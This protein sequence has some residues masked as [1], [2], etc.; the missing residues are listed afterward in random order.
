MRLAAIFLFLVGLLCL[1]QAQVPLTHA[2]KGAPGGAGCSKAT[3]A[4]AAYDGG[5]NTAAVTTLLCGLVTDGVPLDALWLLTINSVGNAEINSWNP[6][7]N[8]ITNVG[9]APT[10]TSNAGIASNAGSGLNLNFTPS[11]A[12]GNCALHN[13]AIG[14][15]TLSSRTTGQ[16]WTAMGGVDAGSN[17][18]YSQPLNGG[19]TIVYDIG[20][21]N[22]PGA[23]NTNANGSVIISRTTSTL[24]TAYFN[25]TS[26]GTNT[27]ADSG[28]TA[29]AL[30]LLGYNNNGTLAQVTGDTLG[31]AFIG[32]LT[33]AQV[34]SAYNRLHTYMN[35][36]A[37]GSGC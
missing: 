5:Q 4:N 19:N 37:P 34:T 31:Y 14:Y 22:F 3:T 29:V 28:I 6:G 33:G 1:T 11:T 17:Y 9:G 15:C 21:S 12:G 10:F 18:T 35:T 32:K 30:Y 13:C 2:G 16:N 26:V 7:T 24:I 20:D 36:V 25:G 27:G 23:A 8:T